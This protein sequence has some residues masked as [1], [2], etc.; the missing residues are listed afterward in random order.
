MWG[1]CWGNCLPLRVSPISAVTKRIAETF[2]FFDVIAE[3]G[4][5][6]LGS[7]CQN[8]FSILATP[9]ATF[10]LLL[11]SFLLLLLL[12]NLSL[13]TALHTNVSFLEPSE[14]GCLIEVSQVYG[15]SWGEATVNS[16][17]CYQPRGSHNDT[18][19]HTQASTLPHAHK[20]THAHT[21][22]REFINPKQKSALDWSHFPRGLQQKE[23]LCLMD[24]I[25]KVLYEICQK[26]TRPVNRAGWSLQEADTLFK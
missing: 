9:F 24:I 25:V 12:T 22:T 21:H 16:S 6:L 17:L 10:L 20:C 15:Q 26:A 11:I 7:N 8:D 4:N 19:M 14:A 2:F 3:R 23:K 1:V 18:D 13:H 5:S